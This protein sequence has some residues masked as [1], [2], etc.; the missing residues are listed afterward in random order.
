MLPK[1]QVLHL[2]M[3]TIFKWIFNKALSIAAKFL[4]SERQIF[5]VRRSSCGFDAVC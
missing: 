3:F 4:Q 5:E 1:M 2:V